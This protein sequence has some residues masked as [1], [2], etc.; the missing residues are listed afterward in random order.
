MGGAALHG[1]WGSNITTITGIFS[2]VLSSTL[3]LPLLCSHIRKA[4][5]PLGP[6]LAPFCQELPYP[7]GLGLSPEPRLTHLISV[8]IST[9]MVH[10]YL[11]FNVTDLN[12]LP[13][14]KLIL[15]L[16]FSIFAH[17]TTTIL[18]ITKEFSHS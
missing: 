8:S 2:K 7:S 14:L 10:K 15:F 16:D 17:G 18:S 4:G 6:T 9:W 5:V 12:S 11:R 3:S 1:H 13:F